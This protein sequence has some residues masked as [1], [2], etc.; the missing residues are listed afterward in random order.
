VRTSD[1]KT[2]LT[3]LSLFLELRA[4]H[5]DARGPILVSVVQLGPSFGGDFGGIEGSTLAPM[6]LING[7]IV[8]RLV[9]GIALGPP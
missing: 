5:L 3:K 7:R 6:A 1:I 8:V 4:N 9:A 2:E